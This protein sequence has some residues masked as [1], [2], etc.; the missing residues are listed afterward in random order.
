MAGKAKIIWGMTGYGPIFAPVY[1][2]HLQAI[3]YASRTL[4]VDGRGSLVGA[5]ST[6][7]MYTHSAENQLVRELLATPEATHLF[8]TESDMVLP[9]DVL[10]RL[11]ALDQPIAAGLY[12]LRGGRG[13]P[14]LYMKGVTP[15]DNPYPHAPVNVFP[16][17][18][19]FRNDC[20]GLGCALIRRDVF[21]TVP[22][23]WFDLKESHYGSDMY[24]YTKV[25]DAGIEV[26]VDPAVKCGQMD[27]VEVGYADYERR[28]TEDPA[29]GATG[30][31]L[32]GGPR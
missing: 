12:F 3:A 17:D 5:G 25:R 8:L 26:W 9:K 19:P 24:F 21:E 14:C 11:L 15:A 32:A 10:P 4:A 27:Y 18:R 30:F 23:P 29:F 6:D 13:A 2:S 7:R 31:V 28:L 20:P 16:T 1:S 22:F